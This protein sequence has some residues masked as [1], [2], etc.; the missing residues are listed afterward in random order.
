MNSPDYQSIPGV[1]L[2]HLEE[3]K[4]KP[5]T[6]VYDLT[7]LWSEQLEHTRSQPGSES[8]F[9]RKSL[10]LRATFMPSNR[11]RG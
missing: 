7:S 4:G 8:V 11:M 6:G 9:Y 10:K 2:G 1:G 5:V 3:A